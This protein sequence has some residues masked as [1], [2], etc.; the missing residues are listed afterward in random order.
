MSPHG[1]RHSFARHMLEAGANLSAVK[2][3]LGHATLA[4]TKRYTIPDLNRLQNI[5]ANAHPRA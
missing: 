3:L 2:E 1:L 5:Y 4:A